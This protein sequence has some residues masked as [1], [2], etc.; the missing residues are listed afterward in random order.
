MSCLSF[1]LNANHLLFFLIFII[2]YIR[3]YILILNTYDENE[4]QVERKFVNMYIYVISNLLS[5][6]LFII[7]K[8]RSRRKN[9][10]KFKKGEVKQ[11]KSNKSLNIELIYEEYSPVNKCLLFLRILM[12]SITDLAAQYFVFIFYIFF[13]VDMIQCDFILIFSILSKYLFSRLLL[14]ADYYKHHHLSI[15]MNILGLILIGIT[16]IRRLYENWSLNIIYFILIKLFCT[17]CYSLE[18][19][20]GKKTLN[21]DFLSPI[22]ILFYKGIIES[23]ILLIGSIPFFFIQ[24]NNKNIFSIFISRFDEKYNIY[25]IFLLMFFNFLY[26]LLIWL[27]NDKFSPNHLAMAMIIEGITE[28][29]HILIFDLD[30]F[31]ENLYISIYEVAI[32]IILIIGAFI[33]NEILILN[34]CGLSEYTTKNLKIKSDEDFKYA[35]KKTFNTSFNNEESRDTKEIRDS[36]DIDMTEHSINFSTNNL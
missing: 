33:H 20:I 7:E 26:N 1:E 5:T 23:I 19:V 9:K 21:G 29:I 24:V 3:Y 12:V 11:K 25:P 32:Y 2:Y 10:Q 30:K 13:E 4:T 6:I 22:S 28:K 36:K 17:I 15:L 34:F 16:D 27:I 18:D 14:K 8:I 31:K 35:N